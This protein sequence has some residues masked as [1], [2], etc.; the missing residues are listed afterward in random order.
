MQ[1][2]VCAISADWSDFVEISIWRWHE[3]VL[4]P[5]CPALQGTLISHAGPEVLSSDGCNNTPAVPRLWVWS[6]WRMDIS[7][8]WCWR[9]PGR[10]TLH[11]WPV[12]FLSHPFTA[13]AGNRT[14][15]SIKLCNPMKCHSCVTL[16]TREREHTYQGLAGIQPWFSVSEMPHFA[17]ANF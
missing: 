10:R 6:P 15:S 4:E 13:T 11:A 3:T 9:Q 16:P 14:M 17:A 8:F 2:P 5:S 1:R 7:L 12:F